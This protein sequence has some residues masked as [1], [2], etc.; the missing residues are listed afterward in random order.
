M[1]DHVHH[2]SIKLFTTRWSWIP[3]YTLQPK[4]SWIRHKWAPKTA[5]FTEIQFSVT[6]YNSVSA[7]NSPTLNKFFSIF[8]VESSQRHFSRFVHHHISFNFSINT[9]AQNITEQP[10]TSSKTAINTEIQLLFPIW[11]F[12]NTAAPLWTTL[13]PGFWMFPGDNCLIKFVLL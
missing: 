1:W 9:P 12:R 8:C 13:F 7:T 3:L 10:Q 6:E 11:K 2:P 5:T 4:T